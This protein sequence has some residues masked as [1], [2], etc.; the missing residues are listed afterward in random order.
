MTDN[1]IKPKARMCPFLDRKCLKEACMI[2]HANF[3]K[4]VIDLLQLNL[5]SLKK[6]IQDRD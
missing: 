5:Y 1:S 3:D 4:C 2:Y 6:A